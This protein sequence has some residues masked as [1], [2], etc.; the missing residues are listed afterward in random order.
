MTIRDAT[1]QSLVKLCGTVLAHPKSPSFSAALTQQRKQLKPTDEPLFEVETRVIHGSELSRVTSVLRALRQEPETEHL[2]DDELE[3]ALDQLVTELEADPARYPNTAERRSCVERFAARITVAWQHFDV[4]WDLQ[5]VVTNTAIPLGDVTISVFNE[6]ASSSWRPNDGRDP[7]L[8]EKIEGRTVAI[9]AVSAGDRDHATRRAAESIDAAL[10]RLRYA[11]TAARRPYPIDNELRFR[12]GD[13]YLT[14]PVAASSDIAY[15]WAIGDAPVLLQIDEPLA[16]AI[17]ETMSTFI[18][19]IEHP[20][21]EMYGRLDRAV[22][23]IGAATDR[24]PYDEKIIA[25][26]TAFE[27][28]LASRDDQLKGVIIALRSMLLTLSCN[29][30]LVDSVDVLD[31][32]EGRSTFV[33]GGDAAPFSELDYRYMR[34]MAMM[35]VRQIR[36]L[37]EASPDLTYTE[38]VT[39]LGSQPQIGQAV[40]W[41]RDRGPAAKSILELSLELEK[42]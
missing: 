24:V 41:L 28:V 2:S 16:N 14:R 34:S 30:P 27:A 39:R 10:N 32:Y 38:F 5:H 37:L 20:P 40:E 6:V 19:R 29:E 35:F 21:T 7:K 15:S 42:Q 26:C 31:L 9:V 22:R 1:K 3:S 4:V 13:H 33:H 17:N 18:T 23:F 12:R 8:L 36:E 25:L 11:V